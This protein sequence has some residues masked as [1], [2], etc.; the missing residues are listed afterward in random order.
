MAFVHGRMMYRPIEHSNLKHT[1][2]PCM[3]RQG[4]RKC[5]G[6]NEHSLACGESASTCFNM[7]KHF[8]SQC[9]GLDMLQPVSKGSHS[10]RALRCHCHRQADIQSGLMIILTIQHERILLYTAGST[11]T[12][13]VRV[14]TCTL[15]R[16]SR[17]APQVDSPTAGC[18]S[19]HSVASVDSQTR[20]N[21]CHKLTS[22]NMCAS[23]L[24]YAGPCTESSAHVSTKNTVP[25]WT[26][27]GSK[28]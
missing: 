9:G 27:L 5:I 16:R 24:L 1:D 18:S 2:T 12:Q 26:P 4:E 25:I 13:H 21:G 19:H 10:R 17:R 14:G 20:W 28:G 8:G 22:K 15:H 11:A 3:P 7:T 6:A 23:G